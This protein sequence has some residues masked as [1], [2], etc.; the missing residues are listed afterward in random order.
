MPTRK[1]MSVTIGSASAPPCWMTSKKIA[2]RKRAW[3]RSSR[4]NASVTSPMKATTSA[5]ALPKPMAVSP[6]RLRMSPA[7]RRGARLCRSGTA[8]ASVSSRRTPSGRPPRSSATCRAALNRSSLSRKV[9]RP[10]SQRSSRA[11]SNTTR[12]TSPRVASSSATRSAVGSAAPSRQ[13]PDN[14]SRSVS[15]APSAGVSS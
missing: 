13:L 7:P 6:M 9:N 10:L 8:S 14:A 5:V 3:P 12:R 2:R 1:L 15:A 4:P 11:L